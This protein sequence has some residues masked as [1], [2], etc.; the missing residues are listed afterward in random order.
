MLP[1]ACQPAGPVRL[2]LVMFEVP[3]HPIEVKRETE[4]RDRVYYAFE[5]V[6]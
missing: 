2:R 6:K 3:S 5:P 4:I 1:T